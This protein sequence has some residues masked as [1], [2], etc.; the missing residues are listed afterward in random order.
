M[1][2]EI[3]QVRGGDGLERA[4]RIRTEVF[5]GEFGVTEDEEFDDLD[6]R[7][8]TVHVIAT[9][10]T[11]DVGTARLIADEE[12]PGVVH[13]TRV[14]VRAEAR[15]TGAGRAMMLALEEI[16]V[17]GY[18][19]G[20]PPKL[21]LELSVMEDAVAFYRSLGYAISDERHVEVRIWHRKAHKVMSRLR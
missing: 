7:A 12:Q 21:R 1:T 5:V 11:R 16:A 6:E 18:A 4:R 10:G 20:E 14:A 15:R 2:I 3:I 9:D 19:A 17:A 13:I 8:G